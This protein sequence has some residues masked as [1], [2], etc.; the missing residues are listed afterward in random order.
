MSSSGT[1]PEEPH[2]SAGGRHQPLQAP[3]VPAGAGDGHGQVGMD[4]RQ[5]GGGGDQRVEPLPRHQPAHA[6]HDLAVRRQAGVD[7]GLAPLLGAQG[8]ETLDVDPG[9]HDRHRQPVAGEVE[10]FGRGI[11]AGG[12]DARRPPEHAGQQL[13]GHG[14]AGGDGDLRPVEHDAVRHAEPRPQHAHGQRRVE[15]DQRGA[16]FVRHPPDLTGEGRRR[17]QHLGV[18]VDGE[19]LGGVERRGPGMGGGEHRHPV[20]RQASPQLPQVGLDAAHLRR[21]VVGDQHVGHRAGGRQRDRNRRRFGRSAPSIG[22]GRVRGGG[23]SPSPARARGAET[24]IL[25]TRGSG[26]SLPGLGKGRGW[27]GPTVSWRSNP[28]SRGAVCFT[29]GRASTARAAGRASARD[30]R[31]TAAAHGSRSAVAMLAATRAVDTRATAIRTPPEPAAGPASGAGTAFVARR[32]LAALAGAGRAVVL[33]ADVRPA[34]AAF[35]GAAFLTAGATFT[36]RAAVRLA[37]GAGVRLAG[38]A[39]VRLAGGAGARRGRPSFWSPRP[40]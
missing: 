22:V 25:R 35:R 11:A 1:K 24:V 33:L 31:R 19:G 30:G 23:P 20:G 16:G 3:A 27:N 28:R 5:Q 6:D 13:A 14:K 36:L 34:A 38:G 32:R 39:G 2:R 15:Q 9:G 18:A 37:G 29:V 10:R 40:P 8:A 4:R 26:G 17:Q 21:E 12:D 7:P